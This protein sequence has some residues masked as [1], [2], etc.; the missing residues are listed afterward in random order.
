M[1]KQILVTGGAGFVGS[2]LCERLSKNPNYEVYSL[3]NYFTG[4]ETN[5]VPN[6]TYIKGETAQISELITFNPD[7]VYHLGEYSRVEQSFDDIEK[8]WRY[9][10]DGIF[11]VLEFVRKV[12]CKIL[13]AGSSTKFGDGGLGRSASP[14]AWTKATNTELVMNYGT[15]FNVPYAITYFYNVYGSREIQSGKYATLIALFKEK[16]KNSEP[17]TIVSPGIQKRNFTHIDDIIDGLIL[18]GENGYGDEFGIGS[19]EA[20]SVLEIAQMFGGEIQMLPERKGNRMTADVISAKTEA[21]GWSPKKTIL[22]YIEICRKNG[23]Q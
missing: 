20:F 14:Y 17:L 11:A 7:M 1:R 18:V 5:H 8:V 9:N 2:H 10:K 4:S 23:W 15:W 19:P 12:G 13:Y 21:L 16:M 3:D 22:E 6:V